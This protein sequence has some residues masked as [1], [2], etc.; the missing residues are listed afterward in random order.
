MNEQ[1]NQEPKGLFNKYRVF[2]VNADETQGDPVEDAFVLRDADPIGV[3]AMRFYALAVQQTN[4]ELHRDL[5]QRVFEALQKS[6]PAGIG[7][8]FYASAMLMLTTCRLF[9]A[10]QV[11]IA[12][13]N[14][15]GDKQ[16][17]G[18]FATIDPDLI[19]RLQAVIAEY[20]SE[21]ENQTVKEQVEVKGE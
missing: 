13:Q 18:V 12:F 16:A 10:D 15:S 20:E 21:N 14:E 11:S 3:Q 6:P 4:P 7:V 19:E 17:G 8:E 5:I 2:K 9:G 1:T